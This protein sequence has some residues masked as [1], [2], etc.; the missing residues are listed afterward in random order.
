MTESKGDPYGSN[1]IN[2]AGHDRLAHSIYG[3]KR[4]KAPRNDGNF[5][6]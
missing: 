4:Q 1:D 3:E 6:R 2:H 5:A